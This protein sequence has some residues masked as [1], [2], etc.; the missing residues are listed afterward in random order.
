LFS[1]FRFISSI[2]SSLILAYR[3]CLIY[4]S[5]YGYCRIIRIY[6]CFYEENRFTPC[7]YSGGEADG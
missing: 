5:F 1:A 3:N 4:S 6:G 2:S 7:A